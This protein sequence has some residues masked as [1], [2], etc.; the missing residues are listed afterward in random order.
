MPNVGLAIIPG[1][2]FMISFVHKGN[3]NNTEKFFK[4]VKKLNI[5]QILKA[6]G[7]IGVQALA[8]ATPVGSG[9]T[10]SAW[11]YEIHGG[12]GQSSIVWTNN[13]TNKGV[14]IAVILNY[15]HG[16]GTGGYVQG[17]DYIVPAIR[18]VFDYIADAAWKEVTSA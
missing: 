7:E 5:E 10:A 8:E 17:R 18:P 9:A 16:T 15:G 3:F 13:H 14:N 11:A 12:S 1:V 4:K 2:N 6:Y